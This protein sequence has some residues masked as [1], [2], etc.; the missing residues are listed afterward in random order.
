MDRRPPGNQVARVEPELHVHLAAPVG[1]ERLPAVDRLTGPAHPQRGPRPAVAV[2]GADAARFVTRG[3][4]GVARAVRIDERDRRPHPSQVIGRPPAEGA[5]ADHDDIARA[6]LCRVRQRQARG[7]GGR[8]LQ[9]RSAADCG[10][11]SARTVRVGVHGAHRR[12]LS[13]HRHPP[14]RVMR[15]PPPLRTLASDAR[16]A[17]RRRRRR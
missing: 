16:S 2:R 10:G 6:P 5:G 4:A 11:P 12:R 8:A 17:A 3:R 9:E 1:I 15:R 13:H 7:G 14:V